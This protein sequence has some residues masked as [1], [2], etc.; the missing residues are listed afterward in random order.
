MIPAILMGS[1][2]IE[3]LRDDNSEI[4][5]FEYFKLALLHFEEKLVLP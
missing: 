1:I 5:R 2:R 4:L 3:F